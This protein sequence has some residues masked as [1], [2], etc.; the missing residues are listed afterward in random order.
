MDTQQTC[1]SLSTDSIESESLTAEPPVSY[2]DIQDGMIT[3]RNRS[4]TDLAA[5]D[6]VLDCDCHVSVHCD[7]HFSISLAHVCP[8]VEDES[9]LCE[10]GCERWYHIWYVSYD[11]MA[12]HSHTKSV[13]AWGK[14]LP[15]RSSFWRLQTRSAL[16]YHSRC[17]KRLPKQFVCFHCGLQKDKN[18][19]I[20]KVQTWYEELLGNFSRLALF[21]SVNS[22]FQSVSPTTTV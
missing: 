5:S 22:H 12:I 16:R 9:M 14:K 13:G 10:G 3:P 18:W 20:I 11:I 15:L 7:S 17:D 2:D 21:R 1:P 4:N 8:Q 6:A 19:E